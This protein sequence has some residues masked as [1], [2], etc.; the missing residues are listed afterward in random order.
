[1]RCAALPT[2]GGCGLCKASLGDVVYQCAVEASFPYNVGSMRLHACSL[3]LDAL[4]QAVPHGQG[5]FTLFLLNPQGGSSVVQRHRK[6][7]FHIKPSPSVPS[8]VLVESNQLSCAPGGAWGGGGK[9][10]VGCV[11]NYV[12]NS[13]AAKPRVPTGKHLLIMNILG[14]PWTPCSSCTKEEGGRCY[15]RYWRQASQLARLPGH[16]LGEGCWRPQNPRHPRRVQL[17]A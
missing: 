11:L 16:G 1:M 13:T 7:G 6:N 8:K 17:T 9:L 15:S 14:G 12:S 10:M 2:A 5:R 3:L 4:G